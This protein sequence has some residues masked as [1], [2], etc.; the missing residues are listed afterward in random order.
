MCTWTDKHTAFLMPKL[1][2]AIENG[3]YHVSS[4]A[5]LN[6]LKIW[7]LI[8]VIAIYYAGLSRGDCCCPREQNTAPANGRATCSSQPWKQSLW[9][10]V[11]AR[12]GQRPVAAS[13]GSHCSQV[14]RILF[15]RTH[16]CR[17]LKLWLHLPL[18]LKTIQWIFLYVLY[19]IILVY[20]FL[21]NVTFINFEISFLFNKFSGVCI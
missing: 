3:N 16:V 12:E 7:F 8:S 15:N 10:W 17:I 19:P 21:I 2:Q 6:A 4:G 11:Q 20:A 14:K 18:Q 13:S 5:R 9:D 1:F